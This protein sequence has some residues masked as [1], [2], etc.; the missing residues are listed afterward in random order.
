MLREAAP[1]IADP[2]PRKNIA[3][4]EDTVSKLRLRIM[5]GNSF[6]FPI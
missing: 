3:E 2:T 4:N 5:S 1:M 6:L